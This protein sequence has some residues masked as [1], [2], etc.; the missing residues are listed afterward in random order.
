MARQPRVVSGLKWARPSENPWGKQIRRGVRYRGLKFQRDL[1]KALPQASAD[2]WFEFC[3]ARGPGHCSPD[4][5]LDIHSHIVVIEC[6]LTDWNSA[7]RQLS[8]LYLPVVS[9]ALGKP[10]IGIIAAKQL[11]YKTDTTKLCDSL[12]IAIKQAFRTIP[13]LH[14]PFPCL[15]HPSLQLQSHAP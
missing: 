13:I 7:E 11:S 1:A 6:K 15:G 5:L 10:T 3:D 2:R 9:L 8:H 12:S 4:L 14:V